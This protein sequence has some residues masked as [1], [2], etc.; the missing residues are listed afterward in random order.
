MFVETSFTQR[1]HEMGHQW[2]TNGVTITTNFAYTFPGWK[3][4][5]IRQNAFCM[6]WSRVEETD[7]NPTKEEASGDMP[8]PFSL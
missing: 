1:R 5:H 3:N 2:G 6:A 7:T 8:L 4:R